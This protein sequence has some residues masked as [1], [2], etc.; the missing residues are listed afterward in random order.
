MG[1]W[2]STRVVSPSVALS[3]CLLSVCSHEIYNVTSRR[4]RHRW[5]L[6]LPQ[7]APGCDVWGRCPQ[8][9]TIDMVL[10]QWQWQQWQWCWRH[11]PRTLIYMFS[12]FVL[13]A[14]RIISSAPFGNVRG[15]NELPQHKANPPPPLLRHSTRCGAVHFK[16]GGAGRSC[17]DSAN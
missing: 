6:Q 16:M 7:R 4:R 12:I 17:A 9:N 13:L 3:R 10:W 2:L 1:I 5:R 14:L 8:R 15:I 11:V